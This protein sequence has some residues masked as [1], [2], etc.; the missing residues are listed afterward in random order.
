MPTSDSRA[1]WC[2]AA[3]HVVSL[4]QQVH[5]GLECTQRRLTINIR[6]Q[7]ALLLRDK[8]NDVLI[9]QAAHRQ[10]DPCLAGVDKPRHARMPWTPHAK[11]ASLAEM[12]GFDRRISLLVVHAAD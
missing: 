8:Y 1:Q 9:G 11:F 12:P 5:R 10:Q 3:D 7:P 6:D 2:F 4:S